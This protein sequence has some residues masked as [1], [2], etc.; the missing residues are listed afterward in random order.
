MKADSSQPSW[1][2]ENWRS[3]LMRGH[4]VA[5]DVVEE[6]NDRKNCQ[7]VAGITPTQR[8][9]SNTLPCLSDSAHMGLAIV[10]EMPYQCPFGSAGHRETFVV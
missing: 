4:Y 3:R 6:I 8:I 9:Q 7:G 2:S 1:V 10:V 5:V